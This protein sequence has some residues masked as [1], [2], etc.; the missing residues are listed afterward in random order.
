MKKLI[1]SIVFALTTLPLFSYSLET[2]YVFSYL[3]KFVEKTNPIYA[4]MLNKFESP[5]YCSIVR[6][7]D[8]NEHPNKSHWSNFGMPDKNFNME[9]GLYEVGFAYMLIHH[10]SLSIYMGGTVDKLLERVIEIKE[11]EPNLITEAQFINILR[12]IF[13]DSVHRHLSWLEE[14]PKVFEIDGMRVYY[15]K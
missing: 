14:E 12:N 11:K 3:R 1:L 2:L 15:E 10:K 13:R 8:C 4:D 9:F 5:C 6:I 7:V